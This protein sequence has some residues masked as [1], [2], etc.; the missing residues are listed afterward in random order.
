MKE[1]H[2][3][4]C[5]EILFEGEGLAEPGSGGSSDF[6]F[7][8]YFYMACPRCPVGNYFGLDGGRVS[9]DFKKQWIRRQEEDKGKEEGLSSEG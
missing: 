4:G 5:K 7:Y 8:C 9:I 6:N 3:V 2:C 1:Y